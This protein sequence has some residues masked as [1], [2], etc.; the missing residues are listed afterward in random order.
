MM[1]SQLKHKTL[2]FGFFIFLGLIPLCTNAQ[3]LQKMK[4]QESDMIS[5]IKKN[6]ELGIVDEKQNPFEI[7]KFKPYINGKWIGEA[8]SYGPYRKGQ[9]P[10]SKG[11][12]EAEIL[13]DLNILKEHWNLLR[14]YGADKNSRNI[15]RVIKKNKLP[16]KVML[17]IWLE[18]ETKD[19]AQKS[20][21]IEQ[22]LN[23]IALANE[24]PEIIAAIN[25]GNETQVFWSW[26]KMEMKNL[27]KYIRIVRK[28][29]TVPVTTADDYNF[30]NKPESKDVDAEIDFIVMHA[31]ALWNGITLDNAFNWL[32]S[33]YYKNVKPLHPEKD[34][35][36]GETGWATNYDPSKKGLGE[37]GA[38]VKG[39]VSIKAQ[40]K[41][42]MQHH[43]WLN[44][45]K[46]TTFLFEA[47]DESWKGGG[48]SSAPKEIEKN[49]GVFYEDRT[50]K[51]SFVDY[52]KQL[53]Q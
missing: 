5:K 35:V 2:A 47:F 49:W 46:I 27:I 4:K 43:K 52:L 18:N 32:D 7:R 29:T 40:E 23:G 39:E 11:S 9:S 25:V 10:D 53:N 41:Y 36:I 12:C 20:K 28:N 16:I 17:G 6:L 31:Y 50:P 38:L 44:K 1:V 13:E 22:V 8:V 14:V 19:T 42:L 3:T 26:H 21:N 33:I 15:L 24:F 37:Q 30:W 34:I 51:K 48:E 45:N